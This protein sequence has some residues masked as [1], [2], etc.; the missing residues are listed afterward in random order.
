[1]AD[2]TALCGI[3]E[4]VRETREAL[5]AATASVEASL[6]RDARTLLRTLTSSLEDTAGLYTEVLTKR[7]LLSKNEVA[8]E[9][10]AVEAEGVLGLAVEECGGVGTEVCCSPCLRIPCHSIAPGASLMCSRTLT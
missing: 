9:A 7:A 3:L 8:V 10:F 4:G 2:R 5:L 1:M 6:T